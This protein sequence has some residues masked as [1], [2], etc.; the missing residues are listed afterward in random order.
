MWYGDNCLKTTLARLYSLESN[1]H[2]LI[3]ERCSLLY[4]SIHFTW[5]WSRDLRSGSKSDQWKFLWVFYNTIALLLLMIIRTSHFTTPTCY[6]YF[7]SV[8]R[9]YIVWCLINDRLPAHSDLDSLCPVSD[10][11]IESAQHLFVQ[12]N[13]DLWSSVFKW[14]KLDCLIPLHLITWVDSTNLPALIKS[15][16]DG[17]IITILWVIWCYVPQQDL[18]QR[19]ATTE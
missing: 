18:L 8:M 4:G 2:C 13:L 5:A 14:W 12:C 16:L 11:N 1:K 9:K 7:V 3:N 6:M 19:K 10:D 17:V 15:F